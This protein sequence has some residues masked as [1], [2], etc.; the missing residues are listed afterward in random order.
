MHFPGT[1]ISTD[2]DRSGLT[3]WSR[4]PLLTETVK[5]RERLEQNHVVWNGSR[6][7]A[8]RSI[9]GPAI[10]KNIK[11]NKKANVSVS[12]LLSGVKWLISLK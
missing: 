8:L 5:Q 1:Y 4:A 11:D 3:V 2:R 6:T 12:P 9:F 7:A 10:M